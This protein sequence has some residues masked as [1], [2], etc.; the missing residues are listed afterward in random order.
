MPSCRCK[1][2]ERERQVT[3]VIR[4][5]CAKEQMEGLY[6]NGTA[7]SVRIPMLLPGRKVLVTEAGDPEYNG[8]YFCTGCNG[9]GFVFTKP[10][11]PLATRIARYSDREKEPTSCNAPYLNC[12][13]ARRFSGQ[14]L[15]WYLSKEVYQIADDETQV[16][17]NDLIESFSFWAPLPT[18]E[19]T[20]PHLN[21]YPNQSSTIRQAGQQTW[22]CLQTTTHLEPPIVEVVD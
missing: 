10:R 20:T 16:F 3:D 8:V 9:N 17:E 11:Y 12:I 1:Q 22:Q 13:F 18:T 5:L 6:S 21:S 7:P 14:E 19:S 2:I 4:L 15:L